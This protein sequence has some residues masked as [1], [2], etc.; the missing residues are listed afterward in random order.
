ME[1][2]KKKSRYTPAQ[3]A[4]AKK[5]LAN[6]AEIKIRMQ[7]EQREEIKRRAAEAGKSV[8]QYLLDLALK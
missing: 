2:Q 7:P 8:N 1:E 4:S 3:A 5:Y 6:L